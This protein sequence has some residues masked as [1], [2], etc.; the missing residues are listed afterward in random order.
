ML[1]PRQSPPVERKT[2]VE[3]RARPSQ[4]IRPQMTCYCRSNSNNT[5]TL[6]CLVGRSFYNT[7]QKC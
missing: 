3:T 5:R 2:N 4:G 6:W 7:G 1:L